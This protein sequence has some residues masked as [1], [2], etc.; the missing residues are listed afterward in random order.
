M[1]MTTT[2]LSSVRIPERNT[3]MKLTALHVLTFLTVVS[4][5]AN[6]NAEPA[7]Y[8]SHTPATASTNAAMP[9]GRVVIS[10]T[11]PDETTKAA[12]LARL[13]EVYGTGQVVDQL[14]VGGVVAP[15][16]WA[17]HVQK[18]LGPNLKAI[19]KGQ[20]AI[21]GNIVAV[22]GEVDSDATRQ[23]LT[24]NFATAL[25][26]TYTIKNGLRVIASSQTVLDQ[27]LANRVIEFENGSALLTESGKRILDEM[28]QTL[29]KL[30]TKKIDI[31]GHTD[32]TGTRPRNVAL[33]LSRAESVRVYLI[34]KGLP[35]QAITTSGMGPDQPLLSNATEDGR[36]RNRRIEFR[37]SQ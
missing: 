18:L 17:S 10:G 36:R 25:N 5:T 7:Q 24:G 8:A 9:V 20:L 21:D 32:D 12:L 29:T 26:P 1:I 11:V 30:E 33:S 16:N 3:K 13:Q 27:T 6:I 15:A 19:H 22:R 34:G 35:A 31:I 2:E 14:T 4:H 23:T 37:V 28:A